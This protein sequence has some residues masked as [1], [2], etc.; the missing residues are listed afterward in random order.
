[1]KSLGG[2]DETVLEIPAIP[3][4]ADRQAYQGY[5]VS[6]KYDPW[7]LYVPRAILSGEI[8]EYRK[9]ASDNG[10][11]PLSASHREWYAWARGRFIVI[12][13]K[14]GKDGSYKKSDILT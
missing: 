2:W 14:G 4:R 5:G 8:K 9:Q 12:G 11:V 10:Y 3:Q 7:F 13:N 6:V 1:M